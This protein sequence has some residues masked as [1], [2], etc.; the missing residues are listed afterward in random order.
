MSAEIR[1]IREAR[2]ESLVRRLPIHIEANRRFDRLVSE[3][4]GMTRGELD[5]AID[6]L[7]ASGRA[8]LV[9]DGDGQI[10]VFGTGES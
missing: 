3:S 4:L 5:R 9:V 10:H 6:D 1:T 7:V 8:E 2:A